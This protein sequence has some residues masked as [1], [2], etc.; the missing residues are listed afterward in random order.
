MRLLLA[1]LLIAP[2]AYAAKRTDLYGRVDTSKSGTDDLIF[3]GWN[4]ACSVAVQ[5]YRYPP[6]G[7]SM[8][9]DPSKWKIGTISVEPDADKEDHDWIFTHSKSSYWDRHRA[10]GA[11]ESLLKDGYDIE[12]FV[13]RVRNAPVAEHPGLFNILHTTIAF[14]TGDRV[15]WPEERFKIKTVRYSPYGHC[16]FITYRD[17]KNL[18]ASYD[19]RL[20]RILEPGVRRQRAR[21]HTTNGILLYKENT[22]L[23]A[24]EEELNVAAEMDPKYPLALYYHGAF[25][26]TQGLFEK[27]LKRFEAAVKISP[28]FIKKAKAAKEFETVLK[29]PEF[30]RI[31]QQKEPWIHPSRKAKE[32]YH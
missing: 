27:G 14:K 1:F 25:L 12:G 30:K 9:G 10:E 3:L 2:P 31:I 26:I 20:V 6:L 7:D 5:Y 13:E 23:Y 4:D 29:H 11:A 21:A 22:D 19:F 32:T 17:E 18:N 28:R 24:A 15:T 16:A 8:T